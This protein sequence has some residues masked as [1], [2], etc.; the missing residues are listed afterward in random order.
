MTAVPAQFRLGFLS[1]LHGSAE[2]RQLYR[3]YVELFVA[4][5]ELGFDSGWVAQH[6]FDASSGRLPSPFPFLAAVA[7]RTRRI[8]LGTAVVTL[9]LEDPL[10]VAED[11]AVLDALSGGRVELGVG[12]G[13]DPAVFAAFGKSIDHRREDNSAGVAALAGAFAGQPVGGTEFRLQPAAPGLAGRLWQA[14]FSQDGARYVGAA[15]SRLL[16]NRATFGSAGRTDAV[17][18]PWAQ[19]YRAAYPGPADQIRIGLS[20]GVYP[21]ADKRAAKAAIEAPVL[22]MA[23]RMIKTG[24]FPAGLSSEEYFELMHISYGSPEEVTARLATDRVLPLATDLIVQFSP[25][26]PALGAAIA[27]LELIATQ[28]APALGWKPAAAG[29]TAAGSSIQLSDRLTAHSF[30]RPGRT[31]G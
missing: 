21:A 31:L 17:Q 18:A 3:D 1:H 8:H 24:R 14:A 16:L 26:A 15:G 7:E 20:R 13:A 25:A 11:A 4:A 2:P 27:G 22:A 19:A 5:E 12:S 9:P 30:S 28:V 23:E 6:H 29:M 10:R